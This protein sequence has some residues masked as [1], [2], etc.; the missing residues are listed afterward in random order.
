MADDLDILRKIPDTGYREERVEIDTSEFE[1]VIN[2]R[3]SVRVFEPGVTIPDSIVEKCL[4]HGLNAP[5]SSNMQPWEFYWVQSPDKLKKLQELCL[6]QA[7]ARTAPTIIVAVARRDTWNRN[8][9]AM[10]KSFDN[11]EKET[12][13]KV[14]KGAYVYYEKIAKLAYTQGFLGSFGFLKKVLFFFKR[15]KG[16]IVP[17]APTGKSDMRV[18]AHKSTALA[19]ENIMLSFRAYG[20][21]SCPMEG[22]DHER[23]KELLGL[24]GTQA[25]ICMAISA[26]KRAENGI[27]GER[28]RFDKDWFIKKV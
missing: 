16:D 14:P 28:I 20:Y 1:K 27:Y 23:V 9:L 11:K 4:E 18:W 17:G 21:D 25:E 15:L 7:A 10:L 26:G 12:G 13:E 6:G 8:R 19:C 5:N 22:L 3:R 24:K 2:S